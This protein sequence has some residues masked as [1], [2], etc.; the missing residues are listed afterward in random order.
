MFFFCF[1]TC[2]LSSRRSRSSAGSSSSDIPSSFSFGASIDSLFD[3][4]VG[5]SLR[6]EQYNHH[7]ILGIFIDAQKKTNHKHDKTIFQ[8]GKIRIRMLLVVMLGKC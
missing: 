4:G 1:I 7:T 3:G 2:S 8:R 6:P 5:D